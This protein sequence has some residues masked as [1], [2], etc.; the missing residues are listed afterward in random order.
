MNKFLKFFTGPDLYK[1]YEKDDVEVSLNLYCLY[2]LKFPFLIRILCNR[3][4][5]FKTFIYKVFI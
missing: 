4:F 3:S 1:I 5:K 2:I